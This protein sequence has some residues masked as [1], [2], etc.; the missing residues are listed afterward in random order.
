MNIHVSKYNN[1]LD[2]NQNYA[3]QNIPIIQIHNYFVFSVL[4]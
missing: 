2:D 3:K 4:Y 1:D